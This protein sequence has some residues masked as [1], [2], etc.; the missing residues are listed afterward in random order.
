MIGADA[1]FG[2]RTPS[3]L[4]LHRRQ[5]PEQLVSIHATLRQIAQ[6]VRGSSTPANGET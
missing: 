3:I 6:R 2:E 1:L 5:A 4:D